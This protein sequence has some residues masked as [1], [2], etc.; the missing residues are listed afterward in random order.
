MADGIARVT[1]RWRRQSGVALT[2]V[3]VSFRVAVGNY[4]AVDR[5]TLSVGDGEFVAIVGPTAAA[6]RR[7]SILP[8]ACSRARRGQL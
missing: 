1:E 8:P 3:V 6:S 7:C 2:D 5:A 4:T